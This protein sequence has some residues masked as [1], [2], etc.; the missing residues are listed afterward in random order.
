MAYANRQIDSANAADTA[1]L[2]A[3]GTTPYRRA[4]ASRL[5]IGIVTRLAFVR[6][7]RD[8]ILR[9]FRR[10]CERWDSF[11][12]AD[13]ELP[14]TRPEAVL[15]VPLIAGALA[16]GVLEAA[17][18]AALMA[19]MTTLATP[20]A[21]TVGVISAIC[22]TLAAE[23]V[24]TTLVA[25]YLE[26]PRVARQRLLTG[27][28]RL[29]IADAAIL[30]V[31]LLG[32]AD[33]AWA[34]WAFGIASALLALVSPALSGTLLATARLCAW[35]R[36]LT[37]DLERTNAQEGA[38]INLRGQCENILTSQDGNSPTGATHGRKVLALP[39]GIDRE[40]YEPA[41]AWV[42]NTVAT[43]LFLIAATTL[44][45]Q[46][47]DI[48]SDAS[49]STH[50]AQR[51]AAHRTLVD[52]ATSGDLGIDFIQWSVTLFSNDALT[53]RRTTIP[54]PKVE[55]T[56][57]ERARRS[58][59]AALI[60]TVRQRQEDSARTAC[61]LKRTENER[62]TAEARTAAGS[63]LLQ[64]L[65]ASPV[66][67]GPCTSVDDV[68]ARLAT[69]SVNSVGLAIT[70]GVESCSQTLTKVPAPR[71]RAIIVIIASASDRRQGAELGR[72]RAALLAAAP[73]LEVIYAYQ[74]ADALRDGRPEPVNH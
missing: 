58:E 61:A 31:L 57:C 40:R 8:G 7:K 51:S 73:W 69:T 27:A 74:L 1:A 11:L 17:S 18:A 21:I 60:T 12:P 63:R 10:E 9:A 68:L 30:L 56:S 66:G 64:A 14:H 24:A 34:V 47:I 37:R 23:A 19:F 70:D 45:A 32:R 26:T 50:A 33:I 49:G 71:G 39:S 44:Q 65:E 42:R 46:Q 29:A 28:I 59:A 22:L 15:V 13:G 38:L 43:V 52:L 53:A 6:V 62:R 67:V 48:F 55:L 25:R 2:D 5:L 3:G 72:R 41:S 16:I 36:Q 54:W 20:V 35:S 4:L